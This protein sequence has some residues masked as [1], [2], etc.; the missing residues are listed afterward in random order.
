MSRP[1]KLFMVALLLGSLG[2]GGWVLFAATTSGHLSSQVFWS[3]LPFLMLAGIA[4][5]AL[6]GSSD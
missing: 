2:L 6:T 1:R 5:R 4:W 3:L